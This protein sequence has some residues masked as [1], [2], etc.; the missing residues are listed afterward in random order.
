M[1][2]PGEGQGSGTDGAGD[3]PARQDDSDDYRED[4]LDL[5][6]SIAR[7]YQAGS[8]S[9]RR[10]A[11][12]SR[13]RPSAAKATGSHP[14]ERDPQSLESSVRRLVSEHGW[15]TDVA[16]HTL[17]GRWAEI[18]GPEVAEHCTPQ[19]FADGE[20]QVAADSTAWATQLRWLAPTVVARMNEDLGHGT[21]LRIKVL[22]PQVPSWKKGPRSVRGRG[23]RDTYG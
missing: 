21:V 7:G 11:K 16:V 2:D 14:D 17:F 19:G 15:E 10:R 20:L 9:R 8:R 12:P 13:S 1:T 6:R 3:G 23:P 4:G 22:G 18:V 5:A